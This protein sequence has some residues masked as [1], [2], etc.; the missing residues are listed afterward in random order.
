MTKN[1]LTDDEDFKQLLSQVTNLCDL[2][3]EMRQP[4][5]QVCTH[6][7]THTHTLTHTHTHTDTKTTK[8]M[9]NSCTPKRMIVPEGLNCSS[10]VFS[11][12][13]HSSSLYPI[14]FPIKCTGASVKQIKLKV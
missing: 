1:W 4:K 3:K 11:K 13:F 14:G 5:L 10:L 2:C 6:T 8:P 12:K 7:H 9:L